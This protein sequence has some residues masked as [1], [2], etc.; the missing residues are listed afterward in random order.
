[1]P[2]EKPFEARSVPEPRKPVEDPRVYLAAERTF[3][4][5]IRTS[6]ALMGFGFL[7]ARFALLIRDTEF[8]G[9]PAPSGRPP[10]SPS[11]G[12]AMVCFGVVV[13]LVSSVRHRRYVDA[14]EAG[15]PNPRLDSRATFVLAGVLTL[16]GLAMAIHIL[17]L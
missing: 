1:M 10:I 5:W 12:F 14:L 13:C 3:L 4:A 16:V 7:I 6:L 15:V 17:T 11:L 9:V 2:G 8:A